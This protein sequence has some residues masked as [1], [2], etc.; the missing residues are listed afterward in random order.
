[1]LIRLRLR[2]R[3]ASSSQG[4][5]GDYGEKQLD[6]QA[7][8]TILTMATLA[9]ATLTMATLTM[10]TLTMATLTMTTLTMATLTMATLTM[11][12]LTMATLT[13]ATLTMATL[14]MATLTMATHEQAEL[15]RL[16]LDC[17]RKAPTIN[18]RQ[19]QSLRES[20]EDL[21]EECKKGERYE[22]AAEAT[23]VLELLEL[24]PKPNRVPDMTLT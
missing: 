20:M 19:G 7:P 3:D 15:R 9:T 16:L 17:L 18:L 21:L 13:T 8:I 10:A 1:M 12:T 14:T 4:F 24:F 6:Q 2:E 22:A 5:R 23:Q 11:A